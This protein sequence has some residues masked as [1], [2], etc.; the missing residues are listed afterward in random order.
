MRC[1]LYLLSGFLCARRLHYTLQLLFLENDWHK[2]IF[3]SSYLVISDFSALDFFPVVLPSVWD[4]K[5]RC[6]CLLV[7]KA[8]LLPERVISRCNQ[9][10]RHA[11]VAKVTKY[12]ME[13]LQQSVRALKQL[14]NC[15]FYL[16]LPY[17]HD[18][19]YGLSGQEYY[20]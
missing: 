19:A 13:E 7:A 6:L 20:F 10:R 4:F 16:C 9:A 3:F 8:F 14:N 1:P 18:L 2:I 12:T 5:L 11:A 17:C 15:D